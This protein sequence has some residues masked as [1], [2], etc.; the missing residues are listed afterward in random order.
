MTEPA[1]PRRLFIAGVKATLPLQIGVIPF[2]LI[3][4]TALVTAGLPIWIAHAFSIVVFAGAAQL[5]MVELISQHAAVGV[6]V[7]TALLINLRFMMYSAAIAPYL[8]HTGNGL[9]A[10]AAYLLTDQAY[11]IS[12]VHYDQ[13]EAEPLQHWYYFGS[14]LTLWTVWQLGTSAGIYLGATLPAS[15]SLDF[16]IPLTFLGLVFPLI[17]NRPGILAAAVA[18]VGAV[19]GHGLPY[20][21]GFLAAVLVGA[22]AAVFAEGKLGDEVRD[23]S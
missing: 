16:A 7:L 13:N 5:A 8:R 12:M 21:M 10:F 15:W 3:T 19:I 1:T 14:A 18:G 9:R 6:I 2:A 22:A 4:G 23:D 17:R 11:A 20:N